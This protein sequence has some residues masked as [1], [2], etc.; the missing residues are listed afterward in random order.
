[1][2]CAARRAAGVAASYAS[3]RPAGDASVPPS[4]ATAGASP[5]SECHASATR[6]RSA[7]ISSRPAASAAAWRCASRRTAA[8]VRPPLSRPQSA[9]VMR[10]GSAGQ[11]VR[12]LQPPRACARRLRCDAAPVRVRALERGCVARECFKDECVRGAW[13]VCGAC[14]ARGRRSWRVAAHGRG[15]AQRD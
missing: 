9:A 7:A 4:A 11:H 6:P 2:P 1:M 12:T 5:G 14:G 15:E 8:T 10:S 3:T 13:V